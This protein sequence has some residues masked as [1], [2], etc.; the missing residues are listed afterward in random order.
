MSDL[1]EEK[2]IS[3]MLLG[4][5]KHPFDSPDYIFEL[6]LDGIRCIAYLEKGKATLRNKRNK[7]VSALYPE[8]ADMHKCAGQRCILDGELVAFTGGKPDFYAVQRRSLMTDGFR[9]G[10]ASRRNPVQF[11]AYDI[12]Y[13]GRERVTGRPLMQRKELL[14][15]TVSEGRNLSLSRYAEERGRELFR[16]TVEQGLEGIVAKHKQGLYHI[17]RRTRDWI[18]IKAMKDEDFIICGYQPDEGGNVK[19]L[20]LGYFDASGKLKSRGKVYLGVSEEDG[21]IVKTFARRGEVKTPWFPGY[22]NI[23]WLRPELVGTVRFMHETES[24]SLRQPVFKGIRSDF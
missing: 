17:G 7:D 9:I 8:L 13:I 4:E 16:L 11:V 22:K 14:A 1:F 21:A 12:L 6:K 15:G 10:M 19:D 20:V 5:E 3:P 24:G 2:N 18:K 23:V